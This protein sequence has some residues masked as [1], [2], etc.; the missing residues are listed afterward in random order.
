MEADAPR[1]RYQSFRE[2]A[3]RFEDEE[4]KKLEGMV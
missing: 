2:G 3:K 4:R 1:S